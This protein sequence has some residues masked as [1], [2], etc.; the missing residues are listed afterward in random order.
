MLVAAAPASAARQRYVSP[1]GSGAACSSGAPC[2]IQTAFANQNLGDEIIIAPGDYGPITG[3]L[4][5]QAGSY[6]HGVQGQPAPRIHMSG[7]NF[8]G[9][10][11]AGSRA[12]YLAIDGG[13]IEALEVAENTTAD[14]IS[15]HAT[16]A[17]ACLVYGTLTDSVCWASGANDMAV[18]G[19][20]SAN[21]TP[22]LRNVTAEATGQDGIGILYEATLSGHI[23]LTAVNVIAHG[24]D[25]DIESEAT[26]PST[27]IANT[28][29]SNFVSGMENGSG[30]AV[31]A[32]AKQT[33][34]PA[35]LNAAIGDFREAP[36]SPTIDAGVN[37]AA[38]GPL[39]LAG[40][41]RVMGASTDIGASEHDPFAGVV[42]AQQTSKVKKRYADVAIACPAG[43][44]S[45][46]QGTVTLTF[47]QKKKTL[48]AGFTAFSIP[49]GSTGSAS[50][51]ISKK[52]S[53]RLAKKGKLATQ[54]TATAT[55]GAGIS[56][57]ATAA[58]K[59]KPKKAKG[60]K[61]K[62]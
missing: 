15:V 44:P 59:L 5:V 29:H 43:V 1:T 18:N 2:S 53:K 48:T 25:A 13:T 54:A 21:F 31:N 11:G 32:T 9:A 23:T 20:V 57:T 47:R 30:G 52:A 7:P 6:A 60:A 41:P 37:A 51:L 22:V 4:L 40:L 26:L 39:D 27:V 42:L 8:F 17:T 24:G 55:D 28:D 16:S 61:K 14:Q 56:G 34:A 35:F 12:S 38:N 50:V 46:C 58:V 36:G 62:G 49:S 10:V 33:A 19:A 45:P 3:S